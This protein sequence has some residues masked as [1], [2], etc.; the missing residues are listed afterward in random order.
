MARLGKTVGALAVAVALLWPMAAA[1][2]LRLGQTV[3]TVWVKDGDNRPAA[4]PDVG[5][6]VLTIFYTDPDVKDQNE[7]FRDLLKA[8]GL[9]RNN[10]R[11]LGIV[12]MKD[13][14]KPNVFIRRVV[15]QRMAKFNSLILTD[16]DHTLKKA[17]DLGDC[18]EKD[19][20]IIIG[21]DRK[22]Y[23]V[24]AGKL[25]ADEMKK[26]VQLIKQLSAK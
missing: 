24:K 2:A 7:P 14:W 22:V 6:K 4:I 11:G 3:N 20:A 15:R 18:N 1:R 25:T 26:A 19:V 23:F 21:K 10:Y 17:W 13:T 9:D 5:K 16:P 12:N 8:S